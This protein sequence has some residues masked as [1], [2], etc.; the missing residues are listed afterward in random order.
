M[1]FFMVPFLSGILWNA[2]C[3]QEHIDHHDSA[4]LWGIDDTY[5]LIPLSLCWSYHYSDVIMSTMAHQITSL[6]IVYSTVYSGTFRRKHQISAPL[7]FVRVI[8]RW[9]ENSPRKGSVTRKMFPYDDVI[10]R[11]SGSNEGYDNTYKW[12]NRC[13]VWKQLIVLSPEYSP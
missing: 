10:M 13:H 3:I 12:V 8:H 4:R 5:V 11:W 2:Q 1:E 9:P 7:T 6:T